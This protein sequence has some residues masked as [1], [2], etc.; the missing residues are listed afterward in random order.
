MKKWIT[1][2]VFSVLFTAVITFFKVDLT[3]TSQ[4][5]YIR[6]GEPVLADKVDQSDQFVFYEANGKSGMFMKDDV[7]SFGSINVQKQTSLLRI[8][9][10]KKRQ[11]MTLLGFNQ[12]L[13][14]VVDSRLLIFLFMFAATSG[15]TK[16]I[17]VVS[18]A[19]KT[20]A[21]KT[22]TLDGISN[23]S[24]RSCDD[25]EAC[26]ETSDLRDIAL[27]FLGLYKVQNGLD[28]DVPARFA[29]TDT[30]TTQKMKIFELGVK[31][32]NDWLTRR[33][34]VGLLGE[35]TGSKSK[36]FYV[37]YDTHMVVKIPPT[38]ITD[39]EK[40]VR[41]IRREV[42]IA[43]HLLP[44]TCI[45]PMV[46][47]VL[48]KV[49]KLPY[50]SSLTP[51]QLEKQYIRFV[52]EHP[53]YQ[54]YLKIGD[55]FAFF[56]ELTNSF[57]LGR[58]IDELHASKDHTGNEIREAPDVAW[59]QEAF[60][61]R[62]GLGALPVFEGLQ[63][64]YRLCEAETKR[65]F[66]ASAHG[67]KVHPY[68]IRNWFLAYIT[69]ESRNLEEKE[70]DE[71]LLARIKDGFST[72]F[73]S[74]QKNVDDLINLLKTQQKSKAFS[75]S[76]QQIENIASNM[77]ALLCLLKEKRLAL[78]DLKPDNL[79]L[80]ADPDAYPGFL[81]NKR[82]FS[83]GVI[84]VETAI[85]L[86]PTRDGTIAQPLLGGTPLYATP[87]HLLRNRTISSNFGNLADALHLQDW[88]ATLAI[89]FKAVAG[90]NLFPRAARSFPG[91][92][93]ILKSSSDRTD[94]DE[95]TVKAMSQK[96]WSAAATDIKTQLLAFSTVLNQLTL[97]VPEAMAPAIKQ[98]LEREKALIHRAIRKHVS[99][100]PLLKS[101]K[102]KVFLL[103]A[104]CET[105]A[106]QVARWENHAQLPDPH[107]Q[108]AP[109]MVAF[110]NNLNRLKQGESEKNRAIAAFISPPHDVSAYSLLEAMFQIAFRAMYKS[111]W[112]ALPKATD[113]SDQQ[114]AVKEDRAMVTTI[115]NDN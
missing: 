114:T 8:I 41:D 53:E 68:Q 28:E 66:K 49:K 62:Y 57:F 111:R 14:R 86:K 74:N 73:K 115:L 9:D 23:R 67:E 44:V 63:T 17:L 78:R 54:E 64:L 110:L 61:T 59:D 90:T 98:E 88:F 96:F 55:R 47:V 108:V 109:R 91:I 46:S 77:L 33:M 112:K 24:D 80:D 48:K 97:S 95:A 76:R 36:C 15:I 99:L 45:V 27:F 5:I 39:M 105:L 31:G 25:E 21:L 26:Q 71:A 42:Q 60:T 12:K 82:A 11:T 37:I 16:L 70:F 103:E 1:I 29:V 3:S 10:N 43:S 92:L 13:I 84:D 83:I 65:I 34:S 81:K 100:S 56:M 72:V 51:E 75:K 6:G 32:T 87:L 85:S 7:T 18:S 102:N 101:E 4:V 22:P 50:E 93:K 30:S 79:F 20:K 69:G 38:P 52:E 35:E 106:K 89:I 113:A 104:S 107:Q 19:V 58:V 94:P 40:Y 2:I